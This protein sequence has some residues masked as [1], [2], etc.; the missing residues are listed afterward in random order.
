MQLHGALR[1]LA[2]VLRRFRRQVDH[3]Q[4]LRPFQFIR[5]LL[6]PDVARCAIAVNDDL[7]RTAARLE[8]A[9]FVG[10]AHFDPQLDGARQVFLPQVGLF[11]VEQALGKRQRLVGMDGE[12]QQAHHHALVRFGR[13]A[14]QGQRMILVV[15]A[16]HV[17]DLQIG[18]ENCCFK[19]HRVSVSVK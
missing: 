5:D 3:G 2:H 16:V 15:I 8:D 7:F 10:L 9:L 18:F 19:G 1:Q 4:V 13:V 12:R 14:R 6:P 11:R 17:G